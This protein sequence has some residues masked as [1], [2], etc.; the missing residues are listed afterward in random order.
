VYKFPTDTMATI[1]DITERL[2]KTDGALQEPEQPRLVNIAQM[3]EVRRNVYSNGT[4]HFYGVDEHGK[5][6]HL[7]YAAILSHFGYSPKASLMEWRDLKSQNPTTLKNFAEEDTTVP[8]FISQNHQAPP[9]GQP[10]DHIAV[11]LAAYNRFSDNLN[12]KFGLFRSRIYRLKNYG[13]HD[14]YAKEIVPA[15]VRNKYAEIKNSSSAEKRKYL[16]AG[17]AGVVGTVAAVGLAYAGMKHGFSLPS[18][19]PDH[20]HVQHAHNVVSGPTTSLPDHSAYSPDNIPQSKPAEAPQ[21]HKTEAVKR[22]FRHERL[23]KFGD[24]LW[25][26]AQLDLKQKLHHDPTNSQVEKLTGKLLKINHISWDKARHLA[27]GT[28][29][30]MPKII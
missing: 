21:E 5:Q 27:I 9:S 15:M 22:I 16:I 24:T 26:H 19:I 1:V 23:R 6:K 13:I 8:D 14:P 4:E 17:A 28:K 2:P 25:H 10:L 29:F 11:S 20:E 12:Y 30:K 3:Q 18:R 7:G